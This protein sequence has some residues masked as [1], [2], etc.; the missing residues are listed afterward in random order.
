[1]PIHF[2]FSVNV[3][4]SAGTVCIIHWINANHDRL[5]PSDRRG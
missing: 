3:T 4:K 2:F 5:D 1:M